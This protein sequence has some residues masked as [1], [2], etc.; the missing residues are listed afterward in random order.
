MMN[1]EAQFHQESYN[2][3]LARYQ[4]VLAAIDHLVALYSDYGAVDFL[5]STVASGIREAVDE[6]MKESI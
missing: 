3:L 5:G 2:K 4:H 1:T 6:A